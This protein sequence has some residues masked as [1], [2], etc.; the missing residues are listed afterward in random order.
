M[1]AV[2]VVQ[3][4]ALTVTRIPP[5]VVVIIDPTPTLVSGTSRFWIGIGKPPGNVS[6]DPGPCPV[7]NPAVVL[8]AAV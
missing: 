2:P 4:A 7:C 1:V 6:W 3:P 5:P 8:E